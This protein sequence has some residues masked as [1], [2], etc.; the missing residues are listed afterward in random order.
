MIIV[1]K[2]IKKCDSPSIE[3]SSKVAATVGTMKAAVGPDAAPS[4]LTS[5][6][7][8]LRNAGLLGEV[9]LV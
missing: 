5:D 7:R 4:A 9:L 2:A 8:N 1:T 3:Y 6:R